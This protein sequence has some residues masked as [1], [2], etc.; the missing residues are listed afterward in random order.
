M[1]VSVPFVDEQFVSDAWNTLD[2]KPTPG[3]IAELWCDQQMEGK[4]TNQEWEAAVSKATMEVRY[5]LP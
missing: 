3:E 4:P 1:S 2:P 5:Y